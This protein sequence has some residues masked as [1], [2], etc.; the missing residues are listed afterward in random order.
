MLSLTLSGLVLSPG[1]GLTRGKADLEQS[2]VMS[3]NPALP[4]SSNMNLT[5]NA[6]C[7]GRSEDTLKRDTGVPPI[8][9]IE[10]VSV[11]KGIA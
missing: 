8:V 11:L 2:T 6:N 9:T 3:F 7:P 5:N 4:S 1:Q 10:A